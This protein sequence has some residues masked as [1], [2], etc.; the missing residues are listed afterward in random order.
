M[1][2]TSF[3][4]PTISDIIRKAGEGVGLQI[5]LRI[6][7]A[8]TWCLIFLGWLVAGVQK[9]PIG[10]MKFSNTTFALS[11]ESAA[12]ALDPHSCYSGGILDTH[13]M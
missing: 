2:N 9:L 5:M 12:F 7:F 11:L 1:V 13:D 4:R 10:A 8:S 6:I 3:I